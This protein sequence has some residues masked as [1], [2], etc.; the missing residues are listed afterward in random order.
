MNGK[1]VFRSDGNEVTMWSDEGRY[2]GNTGIRARTWQEYLAPTTSTVRRQPTK[3]CR[4]LNWLIQREHT[5][6]M[7][8]NVLDQ[9]QCLK[10][11]RIALRAV[12]KDSGNRRLVPL[13]RCELAYR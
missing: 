12:E 8:R 6:A 10:D 4:T 7:A 2:L 9:S 13:T 11:A 3:C 1:D 5:K